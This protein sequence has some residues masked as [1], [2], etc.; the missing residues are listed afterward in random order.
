MRARFIQCIK[1]F[2]AQE[3]G[4]VLVFLSILL[5]PLFLMV[6]LAT[7]S[8]LGLAK[9]RQ[10]QMACDA[11]AKAG[12]VKGNGQASTVTSVAQKVFTANTT[13][14]TGITGPTVSMNAASRTVT[15]AA[16]VAVPNTFM[17]LGGIPTSIYSASATAP[18]P[19]NPIGC[20][21]SLNASASG[22][23]NLTGG[24]SITMTGCG[25]YANSSSSSAVSLSGSS[26]IT[27]GF[28]KVVG[29]YT[30]WGAASINTTNGIATGTTPV[31][32]PLGVIGIPSYSSCTYNNFQ[33]SGTQVINPGVYCNGIKVSG[34]AKLTL[35]PGQYIIDGGSL[36]ISNSGKLSGTNVTIILTK[37]LRSSY[38]TLNVGGNG[39]VTLTAPTGNSSNPFNGIALYQ[40]PNAPS[41]GTNSISGG[42]SFNVS[43]V[44]AFPKQNLNF[45]GG[46]S[47][48]A[49][50]TILIADKLT[51][52]GSGSANNIN[53]PSS[54]LNAYTTGFH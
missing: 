31:P 51:F 54:L 20:L 9:K 11:A 13:N 4:G 39:S 35:N 46:S 6:G 23:I 15:V 38:A 40:D 25:V 14:M 21:Y 10:L 43:G 50:C 19:G 48:A 17:A 16:S 42:G 32:N 27:A 47:S 52:A 33:A 26:T 29:N 22:A 34:N 24:S 7:D 12:A 3:K 28:L 1:L 44:I 18:V 41:G 37:K 8:S 53:C 30:T 5:I 2:F 49:P 36:M 45:S